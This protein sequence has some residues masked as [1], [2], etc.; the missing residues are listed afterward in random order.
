MNVEQ[1]EVCTILPSNDPILET[2]NWVVSLSPDQG[3]LGRCYVTLKAHKGDLADLTKEE[4]L[5]FT[6]IVKK[7]EK[8]I[9][10]AFGAEL[11][12][13][14]CLMNDAFK[15]DPPKPHV[16]WHL[17][18]RYRHSIN[19]AGEKFEDPLFGYHY[20]R[21]QSRKA[22][23]KVLENIKQEIQSKL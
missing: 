10:K 13:W 6:E 7:I 16:H 14:G 12:N 15:I 3:Y 4:W 18:P 5:D 20:E 2:Q 17:R 8:A 19:F 23:A 11:F 22:S 1:C 9:R 21:G